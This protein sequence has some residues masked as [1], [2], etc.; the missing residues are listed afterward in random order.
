MYSG[1]DA[2][3]SR[4]P[5]FYG[6]ES[7]PGMERIIVSHD[8]EC[9]H[10]LHAST[11]NIRVPDA[12]AIRKASTSTGKLCVCMYAPSN[13]GEACS[14]L[15]FVCLGTVERKA[16][17]YWCRMRCGRKSLPG[18]ECLHDKVVVNVLTSAS[19]C[20]HEHNAHCCCAPDYAPPILVARSLLNTLVL[21]RTS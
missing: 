9:M 16:G 17:T 6:W 8:D 7:L 12:A 13:S 14:L 4:V 20:R 18:V 3:C 21:V 1:M 10:I 15:Y 5:I 19:K 2:C 11:T